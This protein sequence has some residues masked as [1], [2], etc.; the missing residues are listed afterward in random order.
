MNINPDCTF[1]NIAS[2]AIPSYKI[3]ED[4]KFLA[5]LDIFP[6]F[7]GHTLVIPKEHFDLVWDVTYIDEYFK[8]VQKIAKHFQKVTNQEFIYSMIHGEGVKHAHVHLMPKDGD[9]LINALRTI[10][11]EEKL[12]PENAEAHVNKFKLV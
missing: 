12:T 7:D 9:E 10:T 6:L 2:G 8:V 5:F 1:C 3:Y 11:P 4:S